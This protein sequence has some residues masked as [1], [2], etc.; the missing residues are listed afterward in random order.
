MNWEL[1]FAYVVASVIVLAVP[2]PTILLV[3]NYAINYGW[4]SASAT[5]LG[6]T[7]GDLAA[8]TASLLGLGALMSTSA[9]AFT[10]LKWIGAAYLIWLG[11]KTWRAKPASASDVE[12]S[13]AF[14]RR[15]IGLHAF[16][17]TALNPKTI[18]F[19]VAFLPQFIDPTRE[20][21][22][23]LLILGGTF[24]VLAAT[25][26]AAYAALAARARALFQQPQPIRWINRIS[27]AVLIAAGFM[28]AMMRRS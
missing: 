3:T 5:V 28:T 18:G 6:V 16:T 14:S 17:V 12:T 1:Y 25:N 24:L 26:A 4:R 15:V 11:V 7:L 2:G 22:S 10:V 8:M 20:G 21:V 19:F 27:G 9:T 23:Q 13:P